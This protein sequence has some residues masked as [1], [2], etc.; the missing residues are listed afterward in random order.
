[1]NL[2]DMLRLWRRH[3]DLSIREAAARIGIDRSALH[4]FERGEAVNQATILQVI[5]WSFRENDILSKEAA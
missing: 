3:N 1:M 4:R 5:T 2:A